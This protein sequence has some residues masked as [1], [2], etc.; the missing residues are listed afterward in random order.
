MRKSVEPVGI[1]SV[2][3]GE[4]VKDSLTAMTRAQVTIRPLMT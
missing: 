4:D 3:R 1:P 2:H